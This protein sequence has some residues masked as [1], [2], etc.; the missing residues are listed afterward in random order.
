VRHIH[1]LSREN[2]NDMITF[3]LPEFIT[4]RWLKH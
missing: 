2:C 3:V 1:R 4:A